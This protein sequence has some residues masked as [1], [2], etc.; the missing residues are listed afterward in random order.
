M[1]PVEE[2]IDMGQP[3]PV[4]SQA[5]EWVD[6]G[7]PIPTSVADVAKARLAKRGLTPTTATWSQNATQPGDIKINPPQLP[8]VPGAPPTTGRQIGSL[9]NPADEMI[10]QGKG[11]LRTGYDIYK[12]VAN[13]VQGQPADTIRDP[14]IEQALQPSNWGEQVGKLQENAGEFMAGEGALAA[15]G[16]ILAGGAKVPAALA[17]GGRML[18]GATSA[19]AIEKAQGGSDTDATIAAA[20]GGLLG[21]ILESTAAGAKWLGLKF[22][23]RGIGLSGKGVSQGTSRGGSAAMDMVDKLNT[24]GVARPTLGGTLDATQERIGQLS[25]FLEHEIKSVPG[26]PIDLLSA[27]SRAEATIK[28]QAAHMDPTEYEQALTALAKYKAHYTNLPQGPIVSLSDAQ[29]A[30]RA[31]GLAGAWEYGKPNADKGM[32][33]VSNLVYGNLKGDIETTAAAHG[34]P[35]VQI[36][37]K[38][39]SELIPLE[40]MMVR[41]VP[42]EARQPVLSLTDWGLIATG[43]WPEAGARVIGKVFGTGVGAG[44]VK[45]ASG[46]RTASRPLTASVLD[47]LNAKNDEANK[48]TYLAKTLQGNP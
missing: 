5:D 48:R 4:A 13:A 46:M 32:E 2:W 45:G 19:A 10:G 8:P 24:N 43:H 42:V 7:Q 17:Y 12:G 40:Q 44:L 39:L 38:R 20:G 23:A 28:A 1:A 14:R 3:T 22:E 33:R 35:D 30:K 11:A 6:V 37:N 34:S 29:A 16:K 21:P 36:L 15:G 47:I 27:V 25:G 31:A 26:Q 9:L 18:A 41:Q